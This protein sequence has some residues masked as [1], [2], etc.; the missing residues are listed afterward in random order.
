[1]VSLSMKCDVNVTLQVLPLFFVSQDRQL[2]IQ[3][4]LKCAS[5]LVAYAAKKLRYVIFPKTDFSVT[6]FLRENY[7][8]VY[9]F[10]FVKGCRVSRCVIPEE[11][12]ACVL[13]NAGSEF[14]LKVDIQP[15]ELKYVIYQ[16]TQCFLCFVFI[17]S[18]FVFFHLY[19]LFL[20]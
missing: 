7:F 3:T 18:F 6:E 9:F 13:K 11:P 1:M 4:Q 10:T 8:L 16:N 15:S 20:F 5:Y 2:H 14:A 17:C 19:P 12:A